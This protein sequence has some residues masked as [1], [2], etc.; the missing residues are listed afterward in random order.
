MFFLWELR[1]LSGHSFILQED[2]TLHFYYVLS[3]EHCTTLSNFFFLILETELIFCKRIFF[4]MRLSLI[5]FT[6][7]HVYC[8]VGE[9]IMAFRKATFKRK[10]P[11]R[12]RGL[13]L[14][15]LW[16][17]EEEKINYYFNN[18]AKPAENPLRE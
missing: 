18:E 15:V 17:C 6:G 2:K 5:T 10:L 3:L 1:D 9:Q 7:E 13:Y 16:F 12:S 14:K 11:S 8:K 4:N